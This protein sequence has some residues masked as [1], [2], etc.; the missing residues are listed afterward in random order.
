M[1]QQWSDPQNL[2]NNE[3][4]LGLRAASVLFCSSQIFEVPPPSYFCPAIVA[5]NDIGIRQEAPNHS[6]G[7]AF[8]TDKSD[9]HSSLLREVIYLDCVRTEPAP[10]RLPATMAVSCNRLDNFSPFPSHRIELG[11]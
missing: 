11:R 1:K 4:T 2:D 5:A 7:T 9:V 6:S 8:S 10:L 3:M